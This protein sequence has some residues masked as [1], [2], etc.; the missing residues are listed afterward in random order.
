MTSPDAKNDFPWWLSYS[1]GLAIIWFSIFH[2]VDNTKAP[3]WLALALCIVAVCM[4]YEILVALVLGEIA[5]PIFGAIAGIP[6]SVALIIGALII[7]NSN[8]K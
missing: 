3:G 5:W 2:R 6:T 7:A 1:V 8:K 4:M